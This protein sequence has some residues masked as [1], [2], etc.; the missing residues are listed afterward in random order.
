MQKFI[1]HKNAI[2]KKIQLTDFIGGGVE[3]DCKNS[4]Y[5]IGKGKIYEKLR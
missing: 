2:C 4:I 3:L 1:I 5:Q